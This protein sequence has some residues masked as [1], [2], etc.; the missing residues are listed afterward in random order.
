[1]GHR[2]H[3]LAA[4]GAV[5]SFAEASLIDPRRSLRRQLPDNTDPVHF[6]NRPDFDLDVEFW[7]YLYT[8][9]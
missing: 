4:K 2:V 3:L 5:C 6:H 9:H 8:Q 1:M 7:P